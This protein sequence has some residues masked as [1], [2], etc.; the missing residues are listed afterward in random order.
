MSRSTTGESLKLATPEHSPEI[1]ASFGAS[2]PRSTG[3][4]RTSP[5]K[6]LGGVKLS[7]RRLFA[8]AKRMERTVVATPPTRTSP[9]PLEKLA[10]RT[11]YVLRLPGRSLMSQYHGVAPRRVAEHAHAH[12]G[13]AE[14]RQGSHLRAACRHEPFGRLQRPTDS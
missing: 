3:R 5:L 14:A 1:N 12:A 4:T 6:T 13:H 8:D 11:E 10:Q 7:P 2:P 9:S